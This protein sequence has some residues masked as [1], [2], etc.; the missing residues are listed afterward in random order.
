MLRN[1][2]L[3]LI[4]KN[5][6]VLLTLVMLINYIY[7]YGQITINTPTLGFSEVCASTTF[8]NYNVS[9]S[10]S[11]VSNIG[12]GNVFTIQLSDST[13]SFVNPT[14]LTTTT[15]T[16]SPVNVSF[17]FPTSVNGN[18]YRI[19]IK[20]S[21]PSSTSPSSVYFAARYAVYNEPFTINNNIQNQTVC[22]TTNYLLS[23]DNNA[24]SPLQYSQLTYQWFKNGNVIPNE[25]GPNLTVTQSGSYYVKVDYGSCN[26]NAYSNVVNVSIMQSESFT[27]NSQGNAT[28]I[29]PVTGLLLTSVINGNSYTYQWYKDNTIIPG[30]INATYTANSSGTYFAVATNNA[31]ILTS[32]SLTLSEDSISASLDCG[33]EINIVPGQNKIITATT[34]AL[35][36]TYKW[37][38]NDVL[39]TGQTINT[40]NVSEP[41]IY[42][43]IVKQN[44]GCFLEM[45]ASSIVSAPTSYGLTI[46][47]SSTYNECENDTETLS[48]DSFNYNSTLGNFDF[49]NTVPVTYNWYKEGVEISGAT[50]STYTISSNLENGT[51]TLKIFLADGHIVTSNP[52]NV[53]LKINEL[54]EISS[55]GSLLCN[56]NTT[57]LLSSSIT[58][59]MYNYAW[60]EASSTTALG[61]DVTYEATEIGNYYLV[62]SF[63]GCDLISNTLTVEQLDESILVTNY[64]N[65]IFIDEGE[66]ITIIASGMDSYQWYVDGSLINSSSE[67]TINQEIEIELIGNSNSC[68]ITKY[69]TVKY[70]SNSFNIVVPNTISPNNDG[71][72]DK[73]IIT[74]EY[75]YKNDIE[76]VIFSSNQQ[77]IY[78]T[79][80]YQNN[81]PSETL[82]YNNKTFYYKILRDNSVLQQGTISVIR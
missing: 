4:S 33:T 11:P 14:V 31:C 60:Y 58:S 72:N 56:T 57:V 81:W 16:T 37:Y 3:S 26:L 39:I 32:N 74:E 27:I 54:L 5:N 6:K 1:L 28:S 48:I 15:T 23:I 67:L 51:Y 35:N 41:G 62:I 24:N 68:E 78:K 79:K 55:D 59:P 50:S 7:G 70:N 73:W 30:A 71:I 13:G 21:N 43:V 38:K 12:S 76:I 36:P 64:E 9:F 42:K 47:H 52:I 77:I 10:F 53:K 25:T 82:G 34:N 66:E 65:D 20:S 40:L 18:N 46:K 8:N 2:P 63:N 80:D 61:T 44:S 17:P 19:R 29:C 45:E 75:A 49:P 22:S 69:L